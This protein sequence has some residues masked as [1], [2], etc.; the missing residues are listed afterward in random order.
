M[1]A[2]AFKSRQNEL[3]VHKKKAA[4][5]YRIGRLYLSNFYQNL[6]YNLISTRRLATRPSSVALEAIGADSPKP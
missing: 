4:N 3:M 6:A 2:E 5:P 1:F